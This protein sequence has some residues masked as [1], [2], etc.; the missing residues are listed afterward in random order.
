MTKDN[1]QG[2]KE[3]E[4]EKGRAAFKFANENGFQA[5]PQYV[6]PSL[7]GVGFNAGADWAR[8]Y[9]SDRFDKL[10]SAADKMEK[11]LEEIE[12]FNPPINMMSEMSLKQRFDYF[13]D[14]DYLTAKQALSEYRKAL[15]ELG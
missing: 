14:H 13:R 8:S 10:K 5:D 15:K 4:K 12:N 6:I 3:Y 9:D 11:A 7:V 2:S 1:P